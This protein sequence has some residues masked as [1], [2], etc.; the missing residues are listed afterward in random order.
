MIIKRLLVVY[1]FILVIFT[2]LIIAV[3]TIP[4]KS[5]GKNIIG[6]THTLEQEGIY[7]RICGLEMFQLDNFTDSY[8]L[9]IAASA[10]E[11]RPIE[12]AMMN[13]N[14]KSDNFLNMPYDTEN[15]AIGNMTGLKES[16]YG[17]Y[18]QGYQVVLRPLLVVMDYNQIRILN[19]IL[20]ILLISICTYLLNK[21]IGSVVACIF[22]LSLLVIN[23]PIV[24][25]SMQFSTCFYIAI[26]SMILIMRYP[27]LVNSK[28]NVLI[29]FFIIGAVTSYLDFLT[30][31]QVTL[32]F[33]LVIYLLSWDSQGKLK[34][35][36]VISL[37]WVLGYGILWA[38]KW[39]I[40]YLLTG[41]NILSDAIQSVELRTSNQYKGVEMSLP[42]MIRRIWLNLQEKQLTYY[43][44][45]GIVISI[46]MLKVYLVKV[47]SKTILKEY[48]FLLLIGA[49]VP[50]W[51]LV[52]RNH[53]L[54]HIWFT[55]RALVLSIF[56]FLL[57]FYFTLFVS[58][59]TPQ[60]TKS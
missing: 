42:E 34:K 28:E 24:P 9:N 58:K 39:G 36:F 57:F 15:A 31:P 37:F 1:S 12:S 44:I 26:I 20:F 25:L 3:H 49:I 52:M 23:F 7:K 27:V 47:H 45:I 14:F 6:S 43:L 51:Y 30:I 46:A 48:S 19:Y 50:V 35:V 59:K 60:K 17:R 22:G 4:K 54:I 29:T 13:Y 5:I 56:S 10:D 8:M 55:W 41:N 40:G 18:W 2:V 53:S 33:P 16:S 21:N 11:S 38:S 32:G